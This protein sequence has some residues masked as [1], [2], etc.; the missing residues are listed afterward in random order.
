M[1]SMMSRKGSVLQ[2]A[3][4]VL[5]SVDK[6]VVVTD[7]YTRGVHNAKLIKEITE[8]NKDTSETKMGL[9]T[10]RVKQESKGI[11]G[12]AEET[13][14]KI[15]GYVPEDENIT[16]FDSVGK[17]IIDLPHDSPGVVAVREVLH[18][19]GF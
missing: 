1:I 16:R 11:I 10:N 14:L 15:L 18:Q 12:I 8:E 13:G 3:G 6:L 2:N 4:R 7:I 17:P 5:R 19:I 9:N